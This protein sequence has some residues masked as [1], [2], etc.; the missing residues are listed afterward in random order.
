MVSSSV[1]VVRHPI[2]GCVDPDREEDPDKVGLAQVDL[3]G[4]DAENINFTLK[5]EALGT[6]VAAEAHLGVTEAGATERAERHGPANLCEL[7]R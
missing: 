2:Q 7:G 5:F 1:P 3:P 6:A 4:H